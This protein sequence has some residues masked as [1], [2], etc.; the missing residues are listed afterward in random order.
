MKEEVKRNMHQVW[1]MIEV[2][3]IYREDYQ[4]KMLKENNISGLLKVRG[5]GKE[6]KSLYRYD[7]RGKTSIEK[8]DVQK[9]WCMEELQEFIRQ[10]VA[11]LYEINEYLLDI[12]CISLEPAHIYQKDRQ[13]YFCYCPAFK[14]N[15]REEF[16]ALAEYFV[17][18]TDYEDKAAVRFASDLHRASLEDTYDI[19]QLFEQL[20]KQKPEPEIFPEKVSEPPVNYLQEEEQILDEWADEQEERPHFIRERKT[21]WDFVSERFRNGT[22]TRHSDENSDTIDL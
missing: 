5:Q 21:V 6:E 8:S 18:E 1:M 10:L 14:G 13:F 20:L 16:H 2:D 4:M 12:N 22:K 9:K 19:E 17:R 3:E 7:V 11:V 15:I